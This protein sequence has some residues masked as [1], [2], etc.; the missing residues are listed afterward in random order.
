MI[1]FQGAKITS[2]T[3][4]LLLRAIDERF[5]ILGPIE[6]EPEDTRL[7]LHSK[8]TE[9]QMTRQRFCQIA[10]GYGAIKDAFFFLSI[11]PFGLPP[12]R[13]TRP[14]QVSRGYRGLSMR[15]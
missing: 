13:R 11:L 1:D 4:F 10:D 14:E 6:S 8:C 9:L 12:A 3:G 15:S 2:D 7:W 5:G